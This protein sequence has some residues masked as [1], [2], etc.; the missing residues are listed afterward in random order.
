MIEIVKFPDK[1]LKKQSL[2]VDTINSEVLSIIDKLTFVLD[3][4]NHCVGIAAVQIGHL[5]RIVAVDVS[6]TKNKN[7]GRLIMINPVVIEKSTDEIVT[8]E[9]CLSVPDYLGYVARPKKITVEYVDLNGKR[10]VLEAKR[11]EA[12]VIQH[13]VDHLD[14]ILFLDKIVSSNQL[15]KRL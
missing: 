12:V 14:G 7:H 5:V 6:K 10:Q 9:G 11:F 13:E 8:K 1:L 2:C 4:Y 15:I 3:F